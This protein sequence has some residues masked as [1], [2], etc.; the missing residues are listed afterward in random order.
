VRG[1]EWLTEDRCNGTLTRV[2]RRP[3]T[4]RVEVR[5]LVRRRT[6][7]LRAGQS[8]FAPRPLGRR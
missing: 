3:R 6:V 1:T 8:H 4:N 5:D 7:L 2:A